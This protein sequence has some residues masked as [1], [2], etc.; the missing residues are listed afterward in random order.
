MVFPGRGNHLWFI[1]ILAAI[2]KALLMHKVTAQ[3][4]FH[5]N[6]LDLYTEPQL[7]LLPA[8]I[9]LPMQG[10]LHF[11]L[12]PENEL[13]YICRQAAARRRKTSLNQIL[14]YRQTLERSTKVKYSRGQ[15]I[16]Y[17]PFDIPLCLSPLSKE[18]SGC[19]KE[20]I[21]AASCTMMS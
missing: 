18:H 17:Q 7:H 10:C 13:Q 20:S 16:F 2:P 1:G 9:Q 21:N 3:I 8:Y 19:A 5:G 12:T 11:L 15:I 14:L 6:N 4:N